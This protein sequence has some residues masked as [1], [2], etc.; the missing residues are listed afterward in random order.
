MT[1]TPRRLP[2]TDFSYGP[3]AVPLS[4]TTITTSTVY[5]LSIYLSSVDATTNRQVTIKDG[6]GLTILTPVVASLAVAPPI[7]YRD[8]LTFQNGIK[9]SCDAADA[10]IIQIYGKR[11]L[12]T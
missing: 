7:E 4:E 11:K 5:V 8:G 6:N 1:Q 12:P 3:I 2:E 9:V 10:V